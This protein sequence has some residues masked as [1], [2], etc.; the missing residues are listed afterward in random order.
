MRSKW[1]KTFFKIQDKIET[2]DVFAENHNM[3]KNIS[4]KVSN[5]FHPVYNL[6]E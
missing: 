2:N 5:L 3:C 1:H 4:W 6:F